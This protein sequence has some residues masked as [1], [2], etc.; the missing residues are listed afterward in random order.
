MRLAIVAGTALAL[1]GI[2]A[3]PALAAFSAQSL[4]NA[5]S[6]SSATLLLQGQTPPSVNC[7]STGSGSGGAVSTNSAT[8]SGDPFPS[9]QLSTT[10]TSATSTLS[11]IGTTNPTSATVSSSSCGVQQVADTSS[12]SDT[13]LSYGGVTYGTNFTS[14]VNSGF[15]ST[16]VTLDG[17][18]TTY[19]GTISQI[20]N[21]SPFSITAWVKTSTSG[22]IIG[23]TNVQSNGAPTGS[24]NDRMLW[25]DSTGV[26]VFGVRNSSGI[27]TEIKSTATVN[28]GAWHFV[29]ATLGSTGMILYVDGTKQTGSNTTVTSALNYNGYWHLGWLST[30]G[31]TDPP[32]TVTL[33]G[34]L[35]E[36]TVFGSV[37]SQSNVTTLNS[38]ASA[39]AYASAVA[40][41]SSSAPY[42]KLADTG[43]VPYTG[44]IPAIAATACS[45]IRANIQTTQG[46][47]TTCAFPT[48]TGACATTPTT[49]LSTF[50]SSAMTAPT[51]GNPVSVLI[52]MNLSVASAAGVL[53][54]H[55]LPGFS[56]AA[57]NH[58]WSATLGYTSATV[59]M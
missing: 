10:T 56:F 51:A 57:A 21:P 3:T 28:N 12:S 8:C 13:G 1:A 14:P 38:A 11:S 2:S 7:Y 43:T 46:T 34:S 32:T 35:S 15:T 31:W 45:Q 47:S 50:S 53:G 16:A 9:A 5:N 59:E 25:V 4:N 6:Y 19:I 48:G 29:V 36:V 30:S 40:A 41:I 27:A 44:T 58:S 20:T 49:A 52:R 33:T 54:L 17:A 26:V 24:D 42:W 55:V 23:F 39:T 22:S 37:L 18:S